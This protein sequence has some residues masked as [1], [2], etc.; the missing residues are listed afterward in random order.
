MKAGRRSADGG[1]TGAHVAARRRRATRCIPHPGSARISRPRP[2]SAEAGSRAGSDR[3]DGSGIAPR[4][5]TSGGAGTRRGAASSGGDGPGPRRAGEPPGSSERGSTYPKRSASTARPDAEG[6]AP[7]MPIASPAPTGDRA[8]VPSAANRLLADHVAAAGQADGGAPRGR[9]SP[10]TAPGP[11]TA[12]ARNRRAWHRHRSRGA[13]RAR[14]G[15]GRGGSAVTPVRAPA[16]SSPTPPPP[17]RCA[18]RPQAGP[19]AR[20]GQSR[21][22]AN[23]VANLAARPDT[24]GRKPPPCFRRLGDRTRC[25]CPIAKSP[26][27]DYPPAAVPGGIPGGPGHAPADHRPARARYPSAVSAR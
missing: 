16:R 21:D 23:H 6:R 13:A 10:R 25:T 24:T 3:A 17:A 18:R 26:I 5:G 27:E 2:A 12:R 19:G 9:R 22:G 15:S 14:T 8:R 7:A 1:A 4:T 11:C 20:Q